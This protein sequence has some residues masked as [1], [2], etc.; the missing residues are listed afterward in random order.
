MLRKMKILKTM[1]NRRKTMKMNKE[2]IEKLFDMM[3][4]FTVEIKQM[5]ENNKLI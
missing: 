4:N 1:K 3:E 2:V 5:K